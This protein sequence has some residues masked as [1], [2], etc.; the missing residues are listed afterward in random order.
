MQLFLQQE[1]KKQQLCTEKSDIQDQH[2]AE[3]AVIKNSNVAAVP[4]NHKLIWQHRNSSS[5][6]TFQASSV[7]TPAWSTH[8]HHKHIHGMK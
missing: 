1:V 6:I 4:T 2:F 5:T 7:S 3:E 8:H